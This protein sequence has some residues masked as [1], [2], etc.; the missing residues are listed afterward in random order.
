LHLVT[1]YLLVSTSVIPKMALACVPTPRWPVQGA[2][3]VALLIYALDGVSAGPSRHGDTVA[4][5]QA[6]QCSSS[7]GECLSDEKP[8]NA[9]ALFQTNL[10]KDSLRVSTDAVTMQGD[11]DLKPN[12]GTPPSS[13][14]NVQAVEEREKR[15]SLATV[16]PLVI[17]LCVALMLQRKTEGVL[18]LLL[19]STSYCATSISMNILNKACV[20]LTGAPSLL[21]AIQMAFAVVATLAPKWKE[22]LGADRKQMLYWC[23]VPIFYAGMLNSSLFAYKYVSLSLMIVFRNL[24]PLVT[25]LVESLVMDAQHAPKVT[26]PAVLAIMMMVMGALL[27]TIGQS[28]ASWI[29]LAVVLLN[30]LLAI[31]DRLIQRRLLV[32]ECTD[33]PLSACM[34]LNNSL[35]MIPTLAVAVATNEVQTIPA[36]HAAWTDPLSLL[37]IGLSG[38]MGLS[39]GF[40]GLMCQKGMTATSF[41][42]LQNLTKIV[43]VFVGV[44]VFG[45]NMSS[46][47]LQGGM[48]LSIVGSAAY[49]LARASE[50]ADKNA[51]SGEG[52]APLHGKPAVHTAPCKA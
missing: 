20:T 42:V 34:V 39:I 24:A 4:L 41:Q 18:Y 50:A 9:A 47:T 1:L 8:Q 45:D 25:M 46:H 36:H 6:T 11:R 43:L 21:T 44:F 35:G 22:V 33:L 48:V 5:L 52:R 40:Y 13:A 29:G 14:D 15:G 30:S 10:Q 49:G 23:I 12:T 7:G 37:L 31:A 2:S 51:S 19:V 16:L 38:L 26:L 27:S 17:F 28:D 3:L 32:S